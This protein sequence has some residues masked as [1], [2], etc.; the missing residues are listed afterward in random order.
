[1]IEREWGGEEEKENFGFRLAFADHERNRG[2]HRAKAARRWMLKRRKRK[3]SRR[4]FG[5]CRCTIPLYQFLPWLSGVEQATRRG[6]SRSDVFAAFTLYPDTFPFAVWG[7][8]YCKAAWPRSVHAGGA[9]KGKRKKRKRNE[10]TFQTNKSST[11]TRGIKWAGR[12]R[13]SRCIFEES[14]KRKSIGETTGETRAHSS[15]SVT[16]GLCATPTHGKIR[17]NSRGSIFVIGK[18]EI[19]APMPSPF[20]PFFP[21]R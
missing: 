9:R 7:L 20:L 8:P 14:L 3:L 17:N 13:C 11:E 19:D 4:T 16:A 21:T 6:S 18:E 10:K 12:C 5:C 1:M 2:D 15:R